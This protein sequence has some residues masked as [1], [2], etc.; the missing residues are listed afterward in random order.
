MR[1]A[2]SWGSRPSPGSRPPIPCSNILPLSLFREHRQVLLAGSPHPPEQLRVRRVVSS[3]PT[4]RANNDESRTAGPWRCE[5]G[6]GRGFLDRNRNTSSHRSGRCPTP[7]PAPLRRHHPA[8]A[9]G[10]YAR[11]MTITV[12]LEEAVRPRPTTRPNRRQRSARARGSSSASVFV[13]YHR[14]G[15]GPPTTRSA[16]LHYEQRSI[17]ARCVRLEI[18]GSATGFTATS[19]T[20]PSPRDTLA[21]L[22]ADSSFCDRRGRVGVTATRA[23]I[24]ST[25][26]PPGSGRPR[27]QVARGR[28]GAHRGASASSRVGRSARWAATTSI[29]QGMVSR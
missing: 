25:W 10:R 7:E 27:S 5:C 11:H 18:A 6:V 14:S 23:G 19:T 28:A 13:T 17:N 1:R 20:R 4:R 24:R 8:H 3:P 22:A 2:C 26:C 29:R 16:G 12:T 21:Q 9:H 15:P